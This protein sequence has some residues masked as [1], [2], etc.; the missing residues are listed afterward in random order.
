MPQPAQQG[1]QL[2]TAV[3]RLRC[4]TDFR[5]HAAAAAAAAG[6]PARRYGFSDDKTAVHTNPGAYTAPLAPEAEPL[7]CITYHPGTDTVEYRRHA[8][9]ARGPLVVAAETLANAADVLK[10][11]DIKDPRI[12]IGIDR[13]NASVVV[14]DNGPG[15]SIYDETTRNAITGEMQTFCS[16]DGVLLSLNSGAN[17]DRGERRRGTCG[18]HGM[19]LKISAFLAEVFILIT[20]DRETRQR[21]LMITKAGDRVARLGPVPCMDGA[22]PTS[23]EVVDAVDAAVDAA[24]ATAD[25]DAKALLAQLAT[26]THVGTTIAYVPSRRF[27]P[28]LF[29]RDPAVSIRVCVYLPCCCRRVAAVTDLDVWNSFNTPQRSRNAVA[30]L[31]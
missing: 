27:M 5:G 20:T 6:A 2:L 4:F 25:A 24:A 8:D 17:F 26:S 3:Q 11:F 9:L 22:D 13:D 29:E 21:V 19:G 31:P 10:Q 12:S 18:T 23:A 28:I 30:T 16:V 1:A 14:H 7:Q 15:L